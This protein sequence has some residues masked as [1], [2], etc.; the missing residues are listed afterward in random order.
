MPCVAK[1]LFRIKTD[2]FL[3]IKKDNL[4]KII[5]PVKNDSPTDF[6]YFQIYKLFYCIIFVLLLTNFIPKN[7]C[8]TTTQHRI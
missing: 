6:I 4:L 1:I 2:H 3:K 7:L 5:I 8:L